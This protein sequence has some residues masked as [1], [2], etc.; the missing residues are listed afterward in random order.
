MTRG[1]VATCLILTHLCSR[2]YL[3]AFPVVIYREVWLQSGS[4]CRLLRG[5]GGDKLSCCRELVLSTVLPDQSVSSTYEALRYRVFD[6]VGSAFARTLRL[7]LP[8]AFGYHY[9]FELG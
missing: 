5:R 8:P 9:A 1:E 3:L 2:K 4:L 6:A 7:Q